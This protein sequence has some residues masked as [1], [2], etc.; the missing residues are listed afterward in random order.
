MIIFRN[1][2]IFLLWWTLLIKSSAI[3]ASQT[4]KSLLNTKN[5][6][7]IGQTDNCV[8]IS[9]DF[10]S[11]K[12]LPGKK[13]VKVDGCTRSASAGQSF[14]QIYFDPNNNDIFALCL[15]KYYDGPADESKWS[16]KLYCLI[17]RNQFVKILKAKSVEE[18]GEDLRWQWSYDENSQLINFN[19]G[20][21]IMNINKAGKIKLLPIFVSGISNF[22]SLTDRCAINPRMLTG[23]N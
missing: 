2:K 13:N 8:T 9:S 6:I 12:N 22:G 4:P 20:G 23:G 18:L 14:K 1:A 15:A 17:G 10:S 19:S 16:P 5:Q 21:R 7:V 3:F 11:P